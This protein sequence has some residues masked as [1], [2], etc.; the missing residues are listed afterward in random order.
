M[1]PKPV[2]PELWRLADLEP[3]WDRLML[4]SHVTRSG[5]R[6]L[7][8]EGSVNRMLAPKDLVAQF[9]D[10]PGTLPAGTVMFCGTLTVQGEIGGAE[11]FEVELIDPVLHRSLTARVLDPEPSGRRLNSLTSTRP[12]GFPTI[13][14]QRRS[15]RRKQSMELARCR[16]HRL[17]NV[18]QANS[19]FRRR[20]RGFRYANDVCQPVT[21]GTN[22]VL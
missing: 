17:T 20:T 5:R 3:H 4:R 2:G 13:P 6:I 22:V 8:Q 1:C 21:F 10:S 7:Y 9:P 15:Q 12:F 11:K 16:L 14:N 18:Y 19:A